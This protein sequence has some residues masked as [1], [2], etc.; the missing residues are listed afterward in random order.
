MKRR[1]FLTSSAALLS[2]LAVY[3]DD[4]LEN[5][6]Q[7]R[8]LIIDGMGEI[9]IE[10]PMSLLSEIIDSGMT[11]VTVTIGNPGLHGPEA[12][13]DALKELSDYEG[14]INANRDYLLKATEVAD[15]D[16]ARN[17]R[18]IALI[19]L[20]QNTTPL[21]DNLE[22][23]RFFYNLGVRS[24]QLTYNSSNLV[25]SGC[26]ER[27]DRGISNFGIG[28]IE[29]LNETG[30]LIDLSHAGM[31][32]M[33]EAIQ[34]SGKPVVISHSGCKSL[35]EHP[36]TTSDENLRA[37]ADKG[38]VI[39]IFQINPSIG[40]KQRNTLDDFIDHIDRAV[41]ITGIDH[42]GIGSDREHQT[43]PDTEEERK[44]LEEEMARVGSKKIHWPFF[45]SELNHP[46]R[47]E[48][49]M[50]ALDSRGY[51]SGDIEKIMGLNFYRVYKEV[52]G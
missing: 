37:L 27:S 7:G 16:R 4:I 31:Q 50:E 15:I 14:H 49:I 23:L 35:Y 17:E 47:M 52:I 13:D 29:K 5:T 43:I 46:R 39:G 32:T 33:K 8:P 21:G 42:V 40:P 18:K 26:M 28:L 3:K 19:Y 10:Y 48:T 25:G 1:G 11:S 38:G 30:I 12:Y 6:L 9:R 44:R 34:F 45:I 22:K 51:R 41:R 20:F 2:G 24:I 36:R